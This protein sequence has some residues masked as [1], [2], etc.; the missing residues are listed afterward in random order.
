MPWGCCSKPVEGG[1]PL[2]EEGVWPV[3]GG[4]GRRED[5]EEGEGEGAGGGRTARRARAR[6]RVEVD[7]EE[8]GRAHV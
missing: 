7:D 2:S 8:I 3:M 5:G 6:V 4:R 1:V